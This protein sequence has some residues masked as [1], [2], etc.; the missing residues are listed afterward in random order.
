[1]L[2]E[3]FIFKSDQHEDKLP[4]IVKPFITIFFQQKEL[5]RNA[6]ENNTANF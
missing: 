5:L 4:W 6:L 2:N 1:M 3:S